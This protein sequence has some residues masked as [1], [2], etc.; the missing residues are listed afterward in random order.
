[1]GA[2]VSGVLLTAGRVTGSA[3]GVT[4]WTLNAPQAESRLSVKMAKEVINSLR[5][6]ISFMA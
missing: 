4:N 3:V 6:K 2:G 5:K 1:V